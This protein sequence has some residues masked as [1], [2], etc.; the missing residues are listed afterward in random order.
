MSHY[1]AILPKFLLLKTFS[2]DW[3][4]TVVLF[5]NPTI[6]NTKIQKV[7][8]KK[9][10]LSLITKYILVKKIEYISIIRS[11]IQLQKSKNDEIGGFSNFH[12]F[13]YRS[14]SN[15]LGPHNQ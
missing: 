6:Q 1:E 3:V 2:F 9:K 7:S 13:P 8:G 15:V 10:R 12:I 5:A 4:S 11:Y 14:S